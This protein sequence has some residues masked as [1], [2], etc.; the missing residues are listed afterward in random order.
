MS[1][2]F[3]FE[4]VSKRYRLGE[5]G[6]GALAY[7]LHRLWASLRRRPDPFTVVDEMS[8]TLSADGGKAIGPTRK[9]PDEFMWALRDVNL[10]V[11]AGSVVGVIGRNG[12]GKSTL[13]KIL[14][15]I[16]TPSAGSVRSN[17]R[18]ISLLE[19]GTGFHPEL[20]GREN[21]LLNGAI[22]GMRRREVL[23]RID[24]IIDFSGCGKHIDTP[25]K[26]YSS[27]M[28]MRLGFAVAAHLQC[29]IL[30]VDEVLAVGDAEFQRRCLGK[31]QSLSQSGD[32]TIVFVSHN[33]NAVTALCQLGLVLEMGQLLT[34][35][36][37]PVHEAVHAYLETSRASKSKAS[38]EYSPSESI[39]NGIFLLDSFEVD[40]RSDEQVRFT[41]RGMMPHSNSNFLIG[42]AIYFAD[43]SVP[44]FRTFS[45]DFNDTP[46]PP[47]SVELFVTVPTVAWNNGEYRAELLF[48]FDNGG[49]VT[50]PGA[51]CYFVEFIRRPTSLGGVRF[52]S[53]Q[54]P[55]YLKYP[56]AWNIQAN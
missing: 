10:S 13:L 53:E 34:D 28:I 37:V 26:R 20:T 1:L 55:T 36:L 24:E 12:A 52:Q 6:T 21:I 48:A 22:L 7:D 16:T 19:V 43:F 15:S 49:W 25:V 5:I 11:E 17:G 56:I 3:Q 39:G 29:D 18:I 33:I 44:L 40:D 38:L 50:W 8:P 46:V 42:I 2:A 54:S 47:G 45:S 27:G 14:S 32:R 23:G 51:F 30:V 35:G 9:S 41:I 31:M 4:N